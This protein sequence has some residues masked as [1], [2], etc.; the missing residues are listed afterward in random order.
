MLNKKEIGI[1][2]LVSLVIGFLMSFKELNAYNAETFNVYIKNTGYAAITVLLNMIV[3]KLSAYRYGCN[4]E[5]RLWTLERYGFHNAQ[6]L[7]KPIPMWILTPL[8]FIFVTRGYIKWL[9]LFVFDIEH[10]SRELKGK[11]Y[12]KITEWELALIVFYSIIA[13]VG[14]A[15]FSIFMGWND[16]AL[17]NAGLA[18]F[19]VIPFSELNGMKIMQG[20]IMLWIFSVIMVSLI[21]ILINISNPITTL[22][23]ALIFA[24][25]V[26]IAWFNFFERK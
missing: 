10:I 7:K 14:L 13:N 8:I 15:I 11:N 26:V 5:F 1:F 16:L 18:L 17:L 20:S 21:V 3:L 6:H 4:V 19:S 9:A 23:S 25:A 2:A 24:F 12:S 22:I